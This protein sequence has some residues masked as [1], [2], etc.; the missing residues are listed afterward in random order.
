M[1]NIEN[2]KFIELD[3]G[4]RYWEDAYLNGKE[5]ANGEIPLRNGDG[6]QP[7]IELATGRVL[8]WPAG[9]EADIHYK[10]CDAGMYWLLD[11]AKRRIAK[12]RDYYVPNDFLCV[13]DNGYGDYIILKIDAG[14]LIPG[15][16]N[17]GVDVDKWEQ[18]AAAAPVAPAQEKTG[19]AKGQRISD[20]DFA[21]IVKR[22]EDAGDH[23]N[24]EIIRQQWAAAKAKGGAA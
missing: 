9:V 12:W 5:D 2:A 22:Y 13:G 6:W 21:A 23:A 19:N 18:I 17:P 7:T 1:S 11:E 3:A 24:A 20:A 8:D 15:W 14:G 4:V 16:R 10:V